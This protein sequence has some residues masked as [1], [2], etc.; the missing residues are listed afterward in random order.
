MGKALLSLLLVLSL[1]HYLHLPLE[2]PVPV[3]AC[4]SLP[5]PYG[6]SYRQP[7]AAVLLVLFDIIIDMI[8]A[9]YQACLN[10]VPHP[11]RRQP[12]PCAFVRP[13]IPL[14]GRRPLHDVASYR[15]GH[16]QG[17]NVLT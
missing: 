9:V 14:L 16:L 8:T 7:T 6:P 13:G 1:T 12:L 17:S 4:R 2:L 15:G 5:A 3:C 10:V 11:L